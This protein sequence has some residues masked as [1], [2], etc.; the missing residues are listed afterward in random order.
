MSWVKTIISEGYRQSY[1][2]TGVVN[3]RTS[4]PIAVDIEEQISKIHSVSY[5]SY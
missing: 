1:V 4:V 5:T 2:L 3:M